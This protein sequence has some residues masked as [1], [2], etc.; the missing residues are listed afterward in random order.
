[1]TFQNYWGAYFDLHLRG[2]YYDDREL[3]TSGDGT[4]LQRPLSGGLYAEVGTDPRRRLQLWA[5]GDVDLRD[6]GWHADATLRVTW[7]VRPQFELELT[8][9]ASYD[10]GIPRYVS[11]D[12]VVGN[13]VTY[14]FGAQTADSVGTTLRASYTFIPELSLQLYSQIFLARVRYG[15]FYA[16]EHQLGVRDRIP[17][18]ALGPPQTTP[19]ASDPNPDTEQATLNINVVL[20]WEY[21][22]GS[23]L[24]LVYTRAQNPSLT[25]APGAA[26]FQLRPLL[27]G[28]GAEDVA[29]LKLTYWW[30]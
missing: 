6:G 22:L 21:R 8:P 15:P 11:S 2:P 27:H 24:F 13:T 23:T 19:P 16:F 29:M 28:R 7:R 9:T 20:R 10:T 12:A 25:P 3:G 14:H 18:S 26:S 30:G 1:M 4:A 17:L 5:G